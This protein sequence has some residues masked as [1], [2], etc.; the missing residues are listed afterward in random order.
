ME[1]SADGLDDDLAEEDSDKVVTVNAPTTGVVGLLP[2]IKPGEIFEY[3]SGC[4]LKT[5]NG[6]MCGS[7]HMAVVDGDTKSGQV[8]DPVDA[9]HSPKDKVFEMPVATFRLI[10]TT[11]DN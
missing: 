4:D 7:F 10:T 2:V 1:D 8:G 5:Q 3:M 11:K 6:T 9:M